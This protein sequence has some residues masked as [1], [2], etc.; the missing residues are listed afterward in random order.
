MVKFCRVAR[1]DAVGIARTGG[2]NDLD[3]PRGEVDGGAGCGNVEERRIAERDLVQ[4]DIAG[5]GIY[6]DE[7][8]VLL[9]AAAVGN[10]GQSPPALALVGREWR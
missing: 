1:I 7:A 10:G 8:R 3:V 5:A 4:R 9:I 2:R 6:L